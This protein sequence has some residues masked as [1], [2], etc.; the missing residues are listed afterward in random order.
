MLDHGNGLLTQYGYNAHLLVGDGGL[1]A[2][3][4]VHRALGRGTR[5][6]RG[7]GLHYAVQENGQFRDPLLYRLWM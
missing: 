6:S 3:G 7:P 5:S 4:A 2:Q 1:R